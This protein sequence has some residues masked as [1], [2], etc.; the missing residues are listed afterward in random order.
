MAASDALEGAAIAVLDEAEPALLRRIEQLEPSA[1]YAEYV[2][3][4][5]LRRIVDVAGPAFLRF[6]PPRL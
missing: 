1:H 3:D 4:P 5:E 2:A 6:F